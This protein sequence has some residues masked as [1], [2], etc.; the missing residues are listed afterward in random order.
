MN[1]YLVYRASFY[2]ML[3]LATMALSGDS[4]EARPFQFYPLLVGVAGII[5]FLTVDRHS[6]WALSRPLANFLAA[7]TVIVLYFEYRL[8][9]SQLIRA[10]GHW[11][12]YLQLI[13]YFLP[14]TP[15]D[16]WFLFLLGLMQVLIGSV[17]SQ[18]DRIGLWLFVWA[19]LAIWVLGQFFLQR[20][21]CRFLS[22][23]DVSDSVRWSCAG[24][25]DPYAGLLDLPYVARDGPRAG[26]DAGTRG[27]DLPDPPATGGCNP[28][29]A[30]LPDGQALDR[31]RRRSGPRSVRRDPGK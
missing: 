26:D 28:F 30:R 10:L 23:G 8:D 11:L 25:V 6:L 4:S 14:K 9:D 12:V 17:V 7:M 3:T 22:S 29:A 18:S 15:M 5:A 24:S 2:M 13:K 1:S 31:L 16:D 19:M 21:A 20:E 27:P